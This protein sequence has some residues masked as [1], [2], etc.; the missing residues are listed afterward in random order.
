MFPL[1][2]TRV[3]EGSWPALS[4]PMAVTSFFPTCFTN[5]GAGVCQPC[6][7]SGVRLPSCMTL[8]D[9]SFLRLSFSI[10]TVGIV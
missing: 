7:G 3:W 8:W 1:P 4:F 9:L 2:V 6:L 10:F 5:E